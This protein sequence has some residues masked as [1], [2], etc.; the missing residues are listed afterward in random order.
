MP[1]VWY[2]NEAVFDDDDGAV[3]SEILVPVD[4][5]AWYHVSE[6]CNVYIVSSFICLTRYYS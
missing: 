2:V 6:D 4:Q 1:L 3:F 5:T